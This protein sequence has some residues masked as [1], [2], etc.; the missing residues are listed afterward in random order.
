MYSEPD[1]IESIQTSYNSIANGNIRSPRR[2]NPIQFYVGQ[3]I[4]SQL[5]EEQSATF[6]NLQPVQ[7]MYNVKRM[8]L[9][10]WQNG[11]AKLSSGFK[12]VVSGY[13]SNGLNY[14][15]SLQGEAA[16]LQLNGIKYAY[17][18]VLPTRIPKLNRNRQIESYQHLRE[19]DFD[20]YFNLLNGNNEHS[21]FVI[22]CQI[23]DID[24]TNRTVT[25]TD[26]D[27]LFSQEFVERFNENLS[28]TH[29]FNKIDNYCT[30][31]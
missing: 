1:F 2:L 6:P 5:R 26:L 18:L 29:F 16:N 21:P 25:P 9:V 31:I 7:G 15:Q 27:N 24:Y 4:N 14:F 12:F 30:N 11:V 19:R 22:G 8:H 3:T 10:I 17:V 23:V 13:S 28:M 20:K